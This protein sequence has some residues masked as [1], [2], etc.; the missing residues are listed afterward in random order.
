MKAKPSLLEVF[1]NRKMVALVFLGFSSGFP[2]YLIN[3]VPLQAWLTKENISLAAITAFNLVALPYSL[4]FLWSPLL[5]RFVPPF[6]GRRRGWLLITQIG[7]L[8][9]IAWMGLQKP[10]EGL[11]LL[12]TAA[13][14]VAFLSASQDIVNDAY[15]TDV[16]TPGERGAG[17]SIFVLGYRVG[18][19]VTGSITLFLAHI[20]PWQ[21]VYIFM[22]LFMLVGVVS[23]IFAPEPIQQPRPPQSLYA[24][25]VLPF[26]EFFQR[27]G[28]VQ[29]FLMLVF[30]I[31]YKLG[32][33]L[34]SSVS[35]AFLLNK[36]LHFTDL[37]IAFP[38]ILGIIAVIV[39]T[40]IG[41]IVITKIGINRS[42]WIFAILQAIGNLSYFVLALVGKNYPLMLIAMNVDNFTVGL[43]SSAFVAFLMSVCNPT[44]SATQYALLTS[45]VA[46]AQNILTAPAGSWAQITGWSLFFL[47]TALAALPGLLL[48]PFF[49]PWNPKP[50]SA[51]KPG[52]EDL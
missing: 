4:K 1:A 28:F 31:I 12:A 33:S 39:G 45:L 3:K 16:L 27:H 5:D 23:S 11:Q 32:Y 17:A 25:V 9:A 29:A 13:V 19:L 42:L 15:R 20:M 10:S 36:G 46:F 14:I 37:E 35:T 34:L 40:L 22:S 18:T 47:L 51:F 43:E 41:G 8:A 21:N 38:N 50:P 52:L 24:A 7:L 30:I 49:A 48:L 6:L 2:L 26:Q 44:F